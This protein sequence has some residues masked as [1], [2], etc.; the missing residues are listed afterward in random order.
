MRRTKIFKSSLILGLLLLVQSC[1][2]TQSG[3]TEP[4]SIHQ[5]SSDM[6]TDLNSIHF[7]N[8]S[9]RNLLYQQD[10][11]VSYCEVLQDSTNYSG[12]RDTKPYPLASLSKV[13]TSSWVLYRFGPD[14]RFKSEWSL[15]AVDAANGIYDAYLKANY[16][17]VINTE[18][19]LFYL[20][21]LN[22][23][24][25][26]SIRELTIDETTR[27]YLSVLNQ[28]HLEL[29]QVPVS[30]E[31]SGKSLFQTMNSENWGPNTEVA[32][33]KLKSWMQAKNL[34]FSLPTSFEV[35]SVVYRPSQEINRDRYNQG[36]TIDSAPVLT[37]LKTINV[38]SN[39]YLSDFLFWRLGGAKQFIQF[40]TQQL[41]LS[42]NDMSVYTGSG[43]ADQRSGVRKD[44]MGSCQSML[45]VLRYIHR[46][47]NDSQVNLGFL[48]LNSSRDIEGTF[49]SKV[50]M[51][52]RTDNLVV[53]TG[54]LFDNPAL[55]LAGVVSTRRGAMYF[56]YLGHDFK[57][58]DAD[59]VEKFRDNM[60]TDLL[61]FYPTQSIFS[62]S[63]PTTIFL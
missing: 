21:Q 40:Q 9:T 16:D 32:A 36:F 56:T 26:R 11:R 44:N 6:N 37:Y 19:I 48:L 22:A 50:P 47:A 63:S 23:R 59:D 14:Y 34:K 24:G 55:N 30:I 38:A 61:K 39:N 27:I 25:V 13:V 41:K 18:K 60:L 29:S 51:N 12:F 35:Q 3:Q 46:K 45:K 4:V 54:R 42:A 57:S 52:L 15:K 8:Q 33:K 17:P 7:S 53:K 62:S 1:G 20:A 5:R 28:P 31:D 49:Q 43:L 2:G 10:S 58:S